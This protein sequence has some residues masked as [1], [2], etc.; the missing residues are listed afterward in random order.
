[1][2]SLEREG[3]ERSEAKAIGLSKLVAEYRFVCTMLLL[4]DTLP[5]VT[6]LSKCFQI[7]A[8]DYSIIPA[9]LSST[10]TSIKQL[11]TADGINLTNLQTY[12]EGLEQANISIVKQHNLGETYFL[13]KIRKPY[14][15]SLIDNLKN[16]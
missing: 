3:N 12:L 9:M 6:H 2:L 13:E 4:C 16:K 5:H 1:M 15:K 14:L 10:I 11:I 7:E 8:V